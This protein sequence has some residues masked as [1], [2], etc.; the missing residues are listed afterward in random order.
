MSQDHFFRGYP[1]KYGQKYGTNVPPLWDPGSP[2]DMRKNPKIRRICR[3]IQKSRCLLENGHH[4]LLENHHFAGTSPFIGTI[5]MDWETSSCSLEIYVQWTGH[6]FL[7]SMFDGF[8]LILPLSNSMEY[9][10]ENGAYPKP[11]GIWR[12]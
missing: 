6:R 4:H 1:T 2:V 9:L 12:C 8:P 5:T 11:A 7:P 3:Y 10:S